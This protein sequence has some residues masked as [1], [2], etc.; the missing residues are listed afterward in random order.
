MLTAH[1]WTL[2]MHPCFLDQI[3]KL[4]NAVEGESWSP[5]RP[6]SANRK[7]LTRIVE[8]AFE[9]IPRD[10]ADPKYRHGGTEDIPRHWFRAKFLGGRFRL[11][12]RFSS[13]EKLIIFGWVNDEETLRAYGKKTD[14]YRVFASRLERGEPPDGWEDLQR[15]ARGGDIRKRAVGIANRVRRND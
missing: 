9:E 12:F 14:A 11:F 2:L 3:E 10:P 8:L 5:D 6:A 15:H 4:A 1:G 7:L 13:E